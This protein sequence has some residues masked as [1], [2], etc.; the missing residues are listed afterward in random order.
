METKDKAVSRGD[1]ELALRDEREIELVRPVA[2]V[3]AILQRFQELEEL[4]RGLLCEADYYQTER[5]TLELKV[6]GWRKLAVAFGLSTDPPLEQLSPDAKDPREF[7]VRTEV[8]V[9]HARGRRVTG[10]GWFSSREIKHK[11]LDDGSCVHPTK[12]D[13]SGAP[14]PVPLEHVVAARA[15]TRAL[16]RAMQDMLGPIESE[17]DE[18][19]V[20]VAPSAAAR[21]TQFER[22]KE[23]FLKVVLGE[24]LVTLIR[25]E[26]KDGELLVILPSPMTEMNRTR[27]LKSM[28]TIGQSVHETAQGLVAQMRAPK[29]VG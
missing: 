2:S 23:D 14:I 3:G 11:W 21:A 12:T 4:K 8:T 28:L 10:V 5:G 9:R 7:V 16:K 13:R 24:D 6:R 25:L 19:D 29:T 18:D 20:P 27:F 26:E 15:Y 1:A 22:F 17:E